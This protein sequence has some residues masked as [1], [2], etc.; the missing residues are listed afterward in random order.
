MKRVLSSVFMLK[1]TIFTLF[2]FWI[3]FSP[4][5]VPVV[6]FTVSNQQ[7][8]NISVAVTSISTVHTAQAEQKINE[9]VA[10]SS[11]DA[12]LKCDWTDIYCGLVKFAVFMLTVI[13]NTIAAIIGTIAD[14]S[15]SFSIGHNI[16]I[17]AQDIAFGAWK[18]IR[19]IS[20]IVII[21]ALFFA[22][23]GFILGSD[24][25]EKLAKLGDP[26]K[27][28]MKTI[29]VAL[30]INFSFFFCRVIIDAGNLGARLIYN[31]IDV[32]EVSIGTVIAGGD[33]TGALKNGEEPIK[34]ITLAMLNNIQAQTLLSQITDGNGRALP[35]TN[36]DGFDL[37][38][39]YLILGFVTFLLD[40]VLIYI[41]T[42]VT[43]LFLG[44]IVM[45][46][47]LTILSPLAMASIPIQLWS[48]D[49]NLG[50]DSW[51]KQMFGNA[52]L[53]V[54][55]LFF[56]YLSILFTEIKIPLDQ[57]TTLAS[58]LGTLLQ[59]LAIMG[60][61]LAIMFFVIFKGKAIAVEWSGV[62]G[63]YLSGAIKTA[64]GFAIGAA[65]GGT[66]LLARQT[67]GRGGSILANSVTGGGA[68]SRG[69][70]SFGTKLGSATYDVRNSPATMKRFDQ[71]VDKLGGGKI[72]MG[73]K[74]KQDKGGFIA[75]GTIGEIWDKRAK[76][77]ADE[78]VKK[79]EAIAKEIELN[80]QASAA[81]TVRAQELVVEKGKQQILIAEATIEN[82]SVNQ[83]GISD[84]EKAKQ[85]K[86]IDDESQKVIDATNKKQSDLSALQV[87]INAAKANGTYSLPSKQ[88][89]LKEKEEKI[90]T[91]HTKALEKTTK[92][93]ASLKTL[94]SFDNK[95]LREITN[96]ADKKKLQADN[97]IQKRDMDKA[98][99]DANESKTKADEAETELKK[100][101]AKLKS[102]KERSVKNKI[103]DANGNMI[104]NPD[105]Q[106]LIDDM[107]KQENDL[108]KVLL[109]KQK[110]NTK[111]QDEFKGK[112]KEYNAAFGDYIKLLN[113]GVKNT[114]NEY[115]KDAKKQDSFTGLEKTIT[116]GEITLQNLK[117]NLNEQNITRK[118]N[119]ANNIND[120]KYS[121]GFNVANINVP[122]TDIN[123]TRGGRVNYAETLGVISNGAVFGGQVNN[124]N[125][126]SA[127]NI[128]T[129]LAAG[130]KKSGGDKPADTNN[131]D[132]K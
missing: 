128:R 105:D 38:T 123:I 57:G 27:I 23:F 117:F 59:V 69:I 77:I 78:K 33:A 60:I 50:W 32:G 97:S 82:A 72:E 62:V 19:D 49:K 88:Q 46:L 68:F 25:G 47:L 51:V 119:Y 54:A 44:R 124:A 101:K 48:K 34:S 104:I 5:I 84:T 85:Q 31:Q 94:E 89:E 112:E 65:T 131:S 4:M 21:M 63:E 11:I 100:F 20:N 125:Q 24:G 6:S 40:L 87:E 26:K 115:I 41:F 74:Y 42:V 55:F 36:A 14:Y 111:K 86:I 127:A 2:I 80:E 56:V 13:P 109:D 70:R 90:N 22:A 10:K 73:D 52:F 103:P 114:K 79:Q 35:I 29:M 81:R 1:K 61:K 129:T 83:I 75:Q 39:A 7:S 93:K 113:D 102:L 37:T 106:K 92:A 30:L 118:Q 71:A 64:S 17:L 120:R 16:Y 28:V 110:E 8:N 126:R 3:G 130:S 45:L 99:E 9:S 95:S 122:F 67:I 18:M 91:D 76:A 116:D 58:S 15:I 132:K 53:G 43:V 96:E 12:A 121:S 107:E 98:K 66:A 108:S